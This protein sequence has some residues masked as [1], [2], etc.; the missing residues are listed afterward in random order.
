MCQDELARQRALNG[1]PSSLPAAGGTHLTWHEKEAA[2]RVARVQGHLETPSSMYL[3]SGA[4]AAALVRLESENARQEQEQR[5][6]QQASMIQDIVGYACG[7]HNGL[8]QLELGNG[9]LAK[10]DL[11]KFLG[12]RQH[13]RPRPAAT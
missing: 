8:Q 5:G 7:A 9:K 10:V 2:S 6:R 3:S 11:R 1:Q 12:R 13:D 4:V